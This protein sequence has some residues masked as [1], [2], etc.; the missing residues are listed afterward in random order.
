MARLMLES[1]SSTGTLNRAIELNPIYQGLR[2]RLAGTRNEAQEATRRQKATPG[3][4]GGSQRGSHEHLS[5]DDEREDARS[6]RQQ[7]I[8]TPPGETKASTHVCETPNK[9]AGNRTQT[10]RTRHWSVVEMD[11]PTGGQQRSKAYGEP[12]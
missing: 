8:D 12:D 4:A 11:E 7:S 1:W 2:K 5:H 9:T 10:T 3:E 6:E